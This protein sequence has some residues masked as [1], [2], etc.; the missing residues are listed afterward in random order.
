MTLCSKRLSAALVYIDYKYLLIGLVG[1][2]VADYDGN[3]CETH[4]I[5]FNFWA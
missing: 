4:R 1:L 5:R 3:E 2:F